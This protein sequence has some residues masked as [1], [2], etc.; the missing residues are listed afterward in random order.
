MK[1]YQ[2]DKD[3]FEGNILRWF[4]PKFECLEG[5]AKT[6]RGILFRDGKL[7]TGTPDDHEG[8]YYKMIK[9]FEDAIQSLAC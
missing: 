1:N 6:L 2:M 8:L 4:A 3:R 7:Y 5:L 9:A